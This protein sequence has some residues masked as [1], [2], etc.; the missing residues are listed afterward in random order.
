[1]KDAVL[2]QGWVE[3]RSS[4]L[5]QWRKRWLVLRPHSLCSYTSDSACEKPSEHIQLAAVLDISISVDCGKDHTFRV[6]LRTQHYLISTP[7]PD[8]MTEWVQQIKFACEKLKGKDAGER[9][10]QLEAQQKSE[11]SEKLSGLIAALNQRESEMHNELKQAH[12]TL[13]CKAE[14][15]IAYIQQVHESITRVFQVF[16]QVY[17][18]PSL[19]SQEKLRQLRPMTSSAAALTPAF[20]SESAAHAYVNVQ[21]AA[22]ILKRNVTLFVDNPNEKRVR[23]TDIT[24]ALKWRYNGQRIDSLTFSLSKSVE[25]TAIGVCIPHKPERVTKLLSLRI[26]PGNAVVPTLPALYTHPA[27][28]A[29]N[30]V[31]DESVSKIL[32]STKVQLRGGMTYTMAAQLEGASTYKC[33]Q[34]LKQVAIDGVSWVFSTSQFPV[35]EQSNRTD[36]DC[37][38]IADFYFIN[39]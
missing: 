22:N 24:R 2:K 37:G 28:E 3:K 13:C 39:I 19:P 26:I 8:L 31:P 7:S 15:E 36:V 29:L 16:T 14:E 17:H 11:V 9:Y 10:R 20:A 25:L 38:P 27:V 35:I 30:H 12:M 32:L 1:M 23:R 18:D 5:K 4:R 33:V 34:C 21:L 6:D